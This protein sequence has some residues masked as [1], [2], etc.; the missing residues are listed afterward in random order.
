MENSLILVIVILPLI[1]AALNGTVAAT[2]AFRKKE[3]WGEK[4]AGILAFGTVATSFIISLYVVFVKMSGLESIA[5]TPYEW[6]S[7]G[8]L[9]INLTFIID[10]LSAVMLLTVTGV[11]SVI[12]L[13]SIGYIHG[14]E[15]SVRYFSYLNL[16]VFAMLL[17]ILGDSMPVMFIGWEGVGLCSYLL[18]GFW[19]KDEEKAMAGKKAFI[20]NRIGDFG[21][22]LGMFLI[23]ANV[24]SLTISNVNEFFYHH[25]SMTFFWTNVA[26]ICLFIGATGK[27]AQIP[28]Y[29]WLPDAMAGP[30]P[31]SALIHAATMVTA[32]VYMVARFHGL[33]LVAPVAMNV[34][35]WVGALTALFSASIALV[36]NDIKKV[37]AYSTVS[38]LG[39]MFMAA[40]AGAFVIAVF[41]LMTHAFFK[42][43]LFLGSGSVIHAM[44]GEQ[45]IRYMGG[46]KKYMPATY[47][48]FLL[49][50][51]AIAGF[52][53]FAGF[54]S[55]DE[56]L[57]NVFASAHGS[58]IV[59]V[60]GALAA[61]FTA[62][63]MF[64]LVYL[65]FF[66]NFRGTREQEH[67]LHESPKTMTVPLMIL[68]GLSV[69]GGWIGIPKLLSLGIFPNLFH[70][71]LEPALSKYGHAHIGHYS[72]ATEYGLMAFSVAI[73]LAGWFFARKK[74]S[75]PKI[76]L[77]DPRNY[78]GFV[79][80]LWNKYFIDEIYIKFII[81][82][83]KSLST[84]I[85]LNISDKKIIDGAANGSAAGWRKVATIFSYFQSGN[86]QAYGFYMVFGVAIAFI[87]A[88]FIF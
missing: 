21:F 28:L 38:Q 8:G 52:P 82:P 60:I 86:M 77:E 66:G 29:V 10:H 16:F 36:Q 15:S 57:W 11:S 2:N 42:A 40:G 62:F 68:G 37:L 53:P 46:L 5:C 33:F 20:V 78:T 81:E 27:S 32:G 6:L 44:G 50:T 54:F 25:N 55:K 39:F 19:Y 7:V 70:D 12:H 41:H 84:N 30:T 87:L 69:I 43:C 83:L 9:Q 80:L 47:I 61:L 64:R 48:T 71:F 49:A 17:L 24:G 65:T 79:K 13:Y 34:V 56:I 4:F 14:D 74:F 26:G 45:D 59:W 51:L 31:V 1:G 75:D 63:Y 76:K 72:H 35:L 3:I 67:H 23:F 88:L 85:F 18:I 58:K 73:A 22:L